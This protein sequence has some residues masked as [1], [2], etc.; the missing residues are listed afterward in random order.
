MSKLSKKDKIGTYNE[1]KKEVTLLSLARKYQVHKSIQL[2]SY[3]GI[4]ILNKKEMFYGFEHCL[5]LLNNLK[6][7]MKE[8][9]EYYGIQRIKVKLKG[10]IPVQYKSQTSDF[11]FIL[12]SPIFWVHAGSPIR[13]I[14]LQALG[15]YLISTVPL[16]QFQVAP[17]SEVTNKIVSPLVLP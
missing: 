14:Y 15:R 17:P 7:A 1:R 11:T 10:L 9:V 4:T 2:I 3:H 5:R 8:Y 13:Y 12:N 6:R 16:L